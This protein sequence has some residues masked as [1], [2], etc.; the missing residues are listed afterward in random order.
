M[1]LPTLNTQNG[2]ERLGHYQDPTDPLSFFLAPCSIV[3]S[4]LYK[5]QGT[6]R[7]SSWLARYDTFNI[8]Q[9]TL[10]PS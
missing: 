10:N 7:K 6:Q 3:M 8:I 2:G 4:R 5:F 1:H 9:P